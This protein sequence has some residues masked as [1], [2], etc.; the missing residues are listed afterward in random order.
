MII[1]A[2]SCLGRVVEACQGIREV[3]PHQDEEGK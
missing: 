3:G 1:N 2:S